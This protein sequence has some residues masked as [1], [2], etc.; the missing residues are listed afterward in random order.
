MSAVY[1]PLPA[2]IPHILAPASPAS[3]SANPSTSALELATERLT[4]I[5]APRRKYGLSYAVPSMLGL[6]KLICT[7][8]N[9]IWT[10]SADDAL[11]SG[12]EHPPW[13]H[14]G[15]ASSIGDD[16]SD[17][18][19]QGRLPL[20]EV[21][22]E[23][24]AALRRQMRQNS[25][26]TK[27]KTRRTVASDAQTEGVPSWSSIATTERVSSP[28]PNRRTRGE[29]QVSTSKTGVAQNLVTSHF[30]T[31]KVTVSTAPTKKRP[32]GSPIA[33]AA[34]AKSAAAGPSS[35]G[36]RPSSGASKR[37]TTPPVDRRG[38][39]ANAGLMTDLEGGVGTLAGSRA[40]TQMVGE[41]GPLDPFVAEEV[42]F[43]RGCTQMELPAPT[44][45][46]RPLASSESSHLPKTLRATTNNNL[47]SPAPRAPAVPFSSPGLMDGSV[48]GTLLDTGLISTPRPPV[49]SDSLKG[50][51]GEAHRLAQQLP[52]PNSLPVN[53]A[54]KERTTTPSANRPQ[55]P[56]APS[57]AMTTDST[58]S[59]IGPPP[60]AATIRK[61]LTRLDSPSTAGTGEAASKGGEGTESLER[62]QELDEIADF[63]HENVSG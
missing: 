43:E 9:G 59:G 47:Q 45:S 24:W 23:E 50:A 61:S 48:S 42:L 26:K 19:S 27:T 18:A 52:S 6:P 62:E 34:A 37:S 60:N 14:A 11:S 1:K 36:A 33:A 53:T 54:A 12:D 25:R 51:A 2:H 4:A 29:A 46:S 57:R 17:T 20:D 3:T 22:A 10:A 5:D 58:A 28:P 8:V 49:L 32:A 38:G 63:L 7:G 13:I 31:S 30:T 55:R 44:A 21:E 39:A 15:R 16:D 40:T 56:T 41:T 35:S